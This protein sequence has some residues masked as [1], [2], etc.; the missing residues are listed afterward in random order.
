MLPLEL[1]KKQVR[2]EPDYHEEDELLSIY[3]LAAQ[4]LVETHT[5]RTL[6]EQTDDEA[7][8]ETTL[9]YGSD[10]EMAMLLLVGHWFANR[11]TVVIGESVN[12]LPLA[13]NALLQPYIR[14][15]I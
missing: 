8:P 2:L 12:T 1:A 6:I 7:D 13:F 11:E 15:G 3:I 4:R 5:R 10:I 9:V 14:Y